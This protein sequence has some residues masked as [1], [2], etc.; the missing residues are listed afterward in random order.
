MEDDNTREEDKAME[1]MM[2]G[3]GAIMA[4]LVGFGLVTAFLPQVTYYCC[5]IC[6]ECFTS[7]ED[8]EAHFAAEH[9]AVDIDITWE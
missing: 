4:L 7:V 6:G 5:P 9:P 3:I 1:S 8:L 2:L